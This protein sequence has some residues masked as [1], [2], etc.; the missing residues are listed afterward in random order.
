MLHVACAADE[1]YVPHCA[2]ML[3]SVLDKNPGAHIHFL[4]DP[5]MAASLVSNLAQMVAL[6]GGV[7]YAHK[8][9]GAQLI[10]LPRLKGIPELMWYRVFLPE[11]LPELDR[12]LYLDSDMLVVEDLSLLWNTELGD[13]YV[14]AVRNVFESEFSDWPYQLKLAKPTAY[15][16]SGMLLLNLMKM[17]DDSISASIAAYG[18][19]SPQRLR[20]PD[21]DALN[22]V[23]S[24][25][26]LLLNPRWNCQNSLFYYRQARELLGRQVVREAISNPAI[27]HFEGGLKPWH[28]LSKHPYRELYFKYRSQTPWPEVELEGRNPFNIILRP[29]PSVW[30]IYILKAV[31]RMRAFSQKVIG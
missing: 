28:Y 11:L 29:L 17:R 14:G 27:L 26:H 30:A 1:K 7:F 2:A 6:R 24:D 9:E 19:S 8:V 16:N 5:A 18:R 25:N 3:L 23:I 20:W 31:Y 12:I 10:G 13:C 22:V 15:F 21:Q 4:H